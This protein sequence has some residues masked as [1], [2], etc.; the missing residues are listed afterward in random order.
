[1]ENPQ[2]LQNFFLRQGDSMATIN[3]FQFSRKFDRFNPFFLAFFP[4]N[5]FSE[6][7]IDSIVD[8][9]PYMKLQKF[10]HKLHKM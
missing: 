6:W 10:K 8:S 2:P 9:F 4:K 1:M 7:L 5:V 3:N